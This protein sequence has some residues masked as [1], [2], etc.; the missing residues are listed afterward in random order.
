MKKKEYLLLSVNL[1][2]K[3]HKDLVDYCERRHCSKSQVAKNLIMD[4]L[5]KEAKN[6]N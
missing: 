2:L 1:P 4:F 6:I 5:E 3:I